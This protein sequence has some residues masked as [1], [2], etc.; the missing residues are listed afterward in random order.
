MEIKGLFKK[1]I[2]RELEGVVTIGNE[3]EKRKIQ[4]LDEYVCTEEVTKNL[5]QFFKAYRQSVQ[6]PNSHCG[7]WITGFFGSGKS[8]F[9]KILG[10]LLSNE[11]VGGKPAAD[12]F[13]EKIADPTIKGDIR[14]SA[15]QDNLVVLFNIDSKAKSNA[16]SSKDS[17]MDTM[18]N[19]FNEKIG[20]SGSIP[21]LAE[22]ERTIDKE[23][24]YEEFQRVFEE[25]SK[26]NWIKSRNQIFFL[27][28]NFIATLQRIK[29][30]SAESA[31]AYFDDCQKNFGI[32]TETFGKMIEEYCREKKKRVVFLIDEVGQF[33]GTNSNLMLGL[34]TVV[35]DLGKYANGKA[36]VVVTSQQ[37]IDAL[38]EGTNRA[39]QLDFSKIQGRFA[40][41][42]T[43]SSANADEV[44]KRRLLEK[45]PEAK[46]YLG[47]IYQQ[48][49]DRLNQLLIFP[50]TPKWSGYRDEQQFIDDYPFV[51]YQYELLQKV[52]DSIRE[53][54]MTEGKSISS[55]E[56]S[57]LSAFK[58]SAELKCDQEVG[59]L[60]P[61]NEFYSTAE[62]FMD[63]N[64]K[65]VFANVIKRLGDTPFD[66]E[67]LKVLF[68]LK[69]VK[70]MEPTLE[71]LSTL[72]V[73]DIHE[74]KAVLKKRIKESLDR[75]IAETFVQQNGERYEFLTNEEQDVN[76]RIKNSTY[77][78]ADVLNGI[79]QIIYDKI[80]DA[81]RTYSYD[82]HYSF[83]LNR[84][85]D[86][87]NPSTPNPDAIT[88]TVLTPWSR[89]GQEP[90]QLSIHR[91]GIVID[92]MNAGFIEE[93]I[94]ANKI[95]YFDRN[96][97]SGASA[98]LITILTKKRAEAEER[99]KRAE[100]MILSA[101]RDSDYFLNGS[102]LT[103]SGR[104]PK[105]RFDEAMKMAI[106]SKFPKLDY[107]KEF[108]KS[109]EDISKALQ[110]EPVMI[111]SL[112][113]VDGSGAAMRE[114]YEIVK[115]NKGRFTDTSIKWLCQKLGKPPFGYRS[116]DVRLMV[117]KMIVN[118]LLK[119]KYRGNVLSPKKDLFTIYRGSDDEYIK[120]EIQEKTDERTLNQVRRVMKDA[121]DQVIEL[122]EKALYED[123]VSFFNKRLESLRE[124]RVAHPNQDYPGKPKVDAMIELFKDIIASEDAGTVFK[125]IIESESKLLD[126]GESLD[127]ILR[128]Y[129]NDGPQMR[130]WK[131]AKELL[132][133]YQDNCMFIADL[134][135]MAGQINDIA[136]ILNNPE[137]F[138][139][140]PQLGSL[141]AEAENIKREINAAIK[142]QAEKEI[143][144]CLKQI[145]VEAE[146]ALGKSFEKAETKDD[147]EAE[148]VKMRN[149]FARYATALE[150]PGHIEQAKGAAR[151][152]VQAFR[153]TL[154]RLLEEDRKRVEVPVNDDTHVVPSTLPLQKR[155]KKVKAIELVPIAEKTITQQSDI[156][157]L[158]ANI[159][160]KLEEFLKDNDEINID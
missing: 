143:D 136:N 71:R 83:P 28:D 90:I 26:K 147:I 132:T 54:G 139:L 29:G 46:N 1:D 137:P 55:G 65:Q 56:R 87:N 15:S 48:E 100:E 77:S 37:Q 118:G 148:L 155:V 22:F 57:L 88:I 14:V 151:N 62:E 17:I 122:K 150:N 76:R 116:I 12:Y 66:I 18:L 79:R 47:T 99:R 80:V 20:Y 60:I 91:D 50:A 13:E 4:E 39:A 16:K 97:S 84:Y 159:K 158:V 19:C 101:L 93:L 53:N 142:A 30:I 41:R 89:G 8:H 92:L 31:R 67:V 51:N 112:M 86:D 131:Q 108:A 11:T 128:F 64:I 74:D 27:R 140:I 10:Y 58:K 102:K 59:L 96:N 3:E 154:Q 120:L 117:A 61:F 36:W 126:Y 44:I 156:D 106:I 115:D 133:Y 94:Q 49:R 25:I 145:Q 73:S 125:R 157:S 160:K 104:D 153:R 75:L 32:N 38:V 63:Y 82:S 109:N 135:Q 43:M 110:A 127:A 149:A 98:S 123:S 105:K 152:D 119:G 144:E 121:F 2:T 124:V 95:L 103:L 23:G 70:E 6:V 69:S 78:Q 130:T 9:L 107:V 7:V 24:Q 146:V 134:G 81:S 129:Q 141:V 35:E 113:D 34:Q 68:M 40:T 42:L 138:N 85:I 45:T 114:I 5:R 72:M 21:W 52:F 111:G 33:I